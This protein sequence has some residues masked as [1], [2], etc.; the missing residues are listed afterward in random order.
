MGNLFENR[1]FKHLEILFFD[2]LVTSRVQ[3]GFYLE[4]NM[5]AQHHFYSQPHAFNSYF[6]SAL[7]VLVGLYVLVIL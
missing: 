1:F 2:I 3:L 6:A 4:V 5:M 7:L